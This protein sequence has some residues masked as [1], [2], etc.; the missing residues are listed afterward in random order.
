M[1]GGGGGGAGGL[2]TPPRGAAAAA[3]SG[4]GA[5]ERAPPIEREREWPRGEPWAAGG[6]SPSAAAAALARG[7]GDKGAMGAAAATNRSW[8]VVGWCFTG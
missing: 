2:G 6:W 8:S 7:C 5:P 3:E 1:R 4:R